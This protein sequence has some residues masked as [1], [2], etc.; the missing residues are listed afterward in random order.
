VEKD[1]ER[2][3]GLKWSR[4]LYTKIPHAVCFSP[5]IRDTLLVSI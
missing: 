1:K 2:E 5:V 3:H 4:L